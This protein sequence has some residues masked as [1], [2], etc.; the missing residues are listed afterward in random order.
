M[1]RESI[2]FL[3][4]P[5]PQFY[6]VPWLPPLELPSSGSTYNSA[7]TSFFWPG[8]FSSASHRL[9]QF[10]LAWASRHQVSAWAPQEKSCCHLARFCCGLLDKNLGG[11]KWSWEVTCSKQTG[12]E[13]SSDSLKLRGRTTGSWM[14]QMLGFSEIQASSF[15]WYLLKV[16]KSLATNPA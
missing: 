11:I 10:C 1:L 16:I 13:G 7:K 4:I 2:R 9:W 8:S 12:G 15:K 3:W 14:F 5:N 6:A